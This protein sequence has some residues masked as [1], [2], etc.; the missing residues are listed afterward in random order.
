MLNFSHNVQMEKAKNRS[1]TKERGQNIE[2]KSKKIVL[3]I[4]DRVADTK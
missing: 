3:E 2:I 4:F 1:I